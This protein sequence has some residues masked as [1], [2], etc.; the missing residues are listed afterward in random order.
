MMNKIPITIATIN[1]YTIPE[2]ILF[3][4]LLLILSERICPCN[5]FL[6]QTYP[7]SCSS[8]KNRFIGIFF[9]RTIPD[10]PY[11]VS[12]HSFSKCSICDSRIPYVINKKTAVATIPSKKT[13]PNTVAFATTLDPFLFM[14]RNSFAF[15]IVTFFNG[16]A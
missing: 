4:I 11:S 10:T 1:Q 2:M 6:K 16:S 14:S 8:D 3:E 13:H 9:S 12:K 7:N 5:K 15:S